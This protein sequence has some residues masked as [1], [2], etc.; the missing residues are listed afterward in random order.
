M[1]PCM[2]LTWKDV[3]AEGCPARAVKR[4]RARCWVPWSMLPE[5]AATEMRAVLAS[6][7]CKET[8]AVSGD[9]GSRTRL[10]TRLPSKCRAHCK[11]SNFELEKK[12]I[13]TAAL[14]PARTLVDPA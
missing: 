14:V 5:A 12:S 2:E 8:E 3:V 7:A 10:V 1:V 11:S 9:K 13:G 6:M 4:R